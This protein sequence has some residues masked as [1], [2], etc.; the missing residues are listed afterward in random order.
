MSEIIMSGAE[1]A[2]EDDLNI[3]SLQELWGCRTSTAA[4]VA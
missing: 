3:L 1:G 4:G 2:L